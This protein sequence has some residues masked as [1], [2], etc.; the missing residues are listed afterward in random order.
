M[1]ENSR[2]ERAPNNYG[3]R[4]VV[5][6]WI[7]HARRVGFGRG[8]IAKRCLAPATTVV[9]GVTDKTPQ[10]CAS[11]AL[12]ETVSSPRTVS[13]AALCRTVLGQTV[14]RCAPLWAS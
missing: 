2:V 12:V 6:W 5:E 10:I 13:V 1:Q 9:R 4:K 11:G 14:W 3:S 7:R 8:R